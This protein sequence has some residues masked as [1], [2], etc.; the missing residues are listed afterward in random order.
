[1]TMD[2]VYSNLINNFYSKTNIDIQK[3]TVIDNFMLA[4]SD[5]IQSAYDEIENNKTP[6][7]YTDIKGENLDSIALFFGMSRK[8]NESDKNFLYR[9]TKWN[10][11][12]KA[13]N[14][15]AIETALMNLTYSSN[16]TYMPYAYGC[17]TAAAYIIPRQLT[18]EYK[19]LAIAEVKSVLQKVTSPSTYINYV[20]PEILPVK[21]IIIYKSS[22]EEIN[23]I[24]N[25]VNEKIIEY[26]NAIPTGEYLEVG[27]INKLGINN[28][29]INY[30]NVV[31]LTIDG[32]EIGSVSALQKVESKFLIDESNI[33]WQEGN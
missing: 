13:S 17:G 27:Y 33:V 25:E 18:D 11:S 7:K 22:Y 9:I 26:I 2:E 31:S 16:V 32:E 6:Y 28:N 4:I 14:L 3:G 10:T 8:A 20:I 29:Y 24:V 23:S 15:D 21:I 12:N 1:M 30:F 5:M 19:E